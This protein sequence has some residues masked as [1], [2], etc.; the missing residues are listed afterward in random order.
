MV[1]KLNTIDV[2]S[3]DRGTSAAIFFNPSQQTFN[4]VK[5]VHIV[6]AGSEYETSPPKQKPINT[7][8][9]GRLENVVEA[10]K[11]LKSSSHYIIEQQ[12]EILK[13]PQTLETY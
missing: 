7:N 10:K 12:K 3:K 9:Y 13:E 11:N 2:E 4:E 6:A 5:E 8:V 1:H